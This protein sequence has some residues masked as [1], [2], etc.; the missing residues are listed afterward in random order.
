VNLYPGA[1]VTAEFLT[2]EE[3]VWL[4]TTQHVSDNRKTINIL[5]LGNHSFSYQ[6]TMLLRSILL[7]LSIFKSF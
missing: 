2:L 1:V 4:L 7:D 5:N 6:C 3:G